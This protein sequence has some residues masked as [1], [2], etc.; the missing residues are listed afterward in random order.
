MSLG[1]Y[2]EQW[3][4]G[5]R[6]SCAVSECCEFEKESGVKLISWGLYVVDLA[7]GLLDD[8]LSLVELL[9]SLTDVQVSVA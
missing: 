7:L 2:L 1:S 8:V 6:G 9:R 4:R 3:Y 5:A